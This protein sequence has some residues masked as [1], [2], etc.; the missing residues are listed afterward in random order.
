MGSLTLPAFGTLLESQQSYPMPCWHRFRPYRQNSQEDITAM[1]S[2]LP[3]KTQ[4]R[5]PTNLI[6]AG[7]CT[8]TRLATPLSILQ[9][10]T[11]AM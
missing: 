1:L 2:D 9:F 4:Q 6:T 11:A 3:L 5:C 8:S 10:T 7:K